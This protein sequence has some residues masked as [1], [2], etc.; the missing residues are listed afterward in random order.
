MKKLL[1]TVYCC[2]TLVSCKIQEKSGEIVYMPEGYSLEQTTEFV[3]SIINEKFI[4]DLN[5]TFPEL[6][7]RERGGVRYQP[8]YARSSTGEGVESGILVN[9]YDLDDY[10]EREELEKFVTLYLK[11]A[12]KKL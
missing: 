11:N 9:L 6:S 5:L 2:L 10:P 7:E 12:T 4:T 3:Q 8:I 1:I